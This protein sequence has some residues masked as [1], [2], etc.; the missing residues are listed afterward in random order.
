VWLLRDF[1][2]D[3]ESEVGAVQVDTINTRFESASV[4]GFSA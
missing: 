4:L 2:L 3:L 1:F